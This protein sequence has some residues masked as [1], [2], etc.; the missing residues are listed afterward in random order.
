MTSRSTVEQF[1]AQRSLGLVGAS[2]TGR[3]FG[4]T[5]LRELVKRGYQVSVVHP[6]VAEIDGIGCYPSVSALPEDV[7]G[8]VLVTPSEQ[9]EKLVREASARGIRHIWMQQ[10]A[11][12]AAAIELCRANGIDA[13]HGECILMFAEPAGIHRFHHLIWK[14]LGKLPKLTL[15]LERHRPASAVTLKRSLRRVRRPDGHHPHH[16]LG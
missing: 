16:E 5:V 13:V 10:G 2:R 12:S 8:L 1:L 15:P 7:G 9:T 4:N 6:E 3:K 14:L 11:E